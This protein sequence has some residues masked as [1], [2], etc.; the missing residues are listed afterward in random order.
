M[1]P[2][3]GGGPP[4]GVHRQ[5]PGPPPGVGRWANP[6]TPPPENPAGI[7]SA[8]LRASS[9]PPLGG[10]PIIGERH[11]QRLHGVGSLLLGVEPSGI[12][13]GLQ[14]SRHPVVHGAHDAV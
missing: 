10:H 1:T 6:A 11:E 7:N 3:T 9:S 8:T 12:V 2:P 14:D 4:A 13:L 5:P